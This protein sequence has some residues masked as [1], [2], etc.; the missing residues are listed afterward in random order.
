MTAHVYFVTI[1]QTCGFVANG[2]KANITINQHHTSEIKEMMGIICSNDM[3]LRA[4]IGPH[5]MYL[6]YGQWIPLDDIFMTVIEI[7]N[8]EGRAK[9]T[10]PIL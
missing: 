3:T 1:E 4:S 7:E 9:Y 2:M 8:L 10:R 6:L 5:F